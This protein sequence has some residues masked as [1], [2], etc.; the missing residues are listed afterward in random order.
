MLLILEYILSASLIPVLTLLSDSLTAS[1][2]STVFP[3]IEVVRLSIS[4]L[5]FLLCSASFRTSSAT[6]ANPLPFSP[7][8]AAS[9]AAFRASKLTFSEMTYKYHLLYLQS[10]LQKFHL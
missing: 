8:L 7:A 1:M 10:A 2:T 9:I 6:T 3:C 4:P 5:D